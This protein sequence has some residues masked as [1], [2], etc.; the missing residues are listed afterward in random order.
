MTIPLMVRLLM[1]M[2]MILVMRL[3]MI[4]PM[5]AVKVLLTQWCNT[6]LM[7][8]GGDGCP[9]LRPD[10]PFSRNTRVQPTQL[11]SP[12]IRQEACDADAELIR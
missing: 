10:L 5:Q 2:T 11:Q 9:R 6:D 1:T 12:G 8:F 3:I 4:L 7:F